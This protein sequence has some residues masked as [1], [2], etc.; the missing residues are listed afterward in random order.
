M[1]E[2]EFLP[3]SDLAKQLKEF[4]YEVTGM[5]SSAEKGLTFLEETLG[6]DRFPDAVLM[7]ITLK[8]EIDGIQAAGVIFEKYP[9]GVVFLTALSMLSV[10]EKIIAVRPVPFLI[11][12]FDPYLVHTNLQ[13]AI[14]IAGLEK[15]I[16]RLR[17]GNIQA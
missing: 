1:F 14:H 15:E 8:G 5:F 12:P 6:T 17:N 16:R 9:C 3:A 10:I 4:G 7:D 13:V 2:D 11:K